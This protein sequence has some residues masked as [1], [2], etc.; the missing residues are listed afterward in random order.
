MSAQSYGKEA[1]EELVV[2]NVITRLNS[3]LR[4]NYSIDFFMA[5]L[6]Q[7]LLYVFYVAY[8]ILGK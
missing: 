1:F 3:F 4:N 8:F 5:V 2:L 6:L 7:C